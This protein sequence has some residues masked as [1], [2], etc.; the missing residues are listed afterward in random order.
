MN[1]HK[2]LGLPFYKIASKPSVVKFSIGSIPLDVDALALSTSLLVYISNERSFLWWV[3]FKVSLL[4]LFALI[5]IF[6]VEHL[7][8]SMT[9]E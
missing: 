8:L 5:L 9:Y 1:W 6:F 3:F 2:R 7:R 4:F